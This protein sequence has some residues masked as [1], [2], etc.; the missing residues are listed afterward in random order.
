MAIR[1]ALEQTGEGNRNLF[2]ATIASCRLP[3]LV[4]ILWA[5]VPRAAWSQTPSPLQE[6]QYSGG[7]ALEK[8]FEPNLPDW[9][10]ALGAGGEYKPL[11]DGA[12]LTRTQAGPVVNVR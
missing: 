3:W 8:L 5:C 7:I 9:R 4:V 11:Y 1:A 10:I 6:W 2:E 12:Q